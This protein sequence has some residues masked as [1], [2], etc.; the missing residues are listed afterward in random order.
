MFEVGEKP[1]FGTLLR[2]LTVAVDDGERAVRL[3]PA[4][5]VEPGQRYSV[6]LEPARRRHL[7][8]AG[9]VSAGSYRGGR[10]WCYCPRWKNGGPTDRRWWQSAKELGSPKDDLT[11]ELR[12]WREG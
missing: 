6:V 11:F 2:E 3:R 7:F 1:P 8:S 10:L 12:F 9:F 4:P 5:V